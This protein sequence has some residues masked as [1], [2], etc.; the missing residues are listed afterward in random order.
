MIKF[1]KR[2]TTQTYILARCRVNRKVD[3]VSWLQAY[4]EP[5]LVVVLL[6]LT[7]GFLVLLRK[8][9]FDIIH[10]TNISTFRVGL[11]GFLFVL[12]QIQSVGAD[13]ATLMFMTIFIVSLFVT[14]PIYVRDQKTKNAPSDGYAPIFFTSSFFLTVGISIFP[15]TVV[16]PHSD[17]ISGFIPLYL[18]IGLVGALVG[19]VVNKSV[20]NH[21]SSDDSGGDE[22]KLD[23]TGNNPESSE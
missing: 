5:L 16:I 23:N 11:I 6:I 10:H 1:E 4:S 22:E 14:Y 8:Y 9:L 21:V 17:R 15:K 12:I 3:W 13:I 2:Q 19:I 7:I 20:P 18:A